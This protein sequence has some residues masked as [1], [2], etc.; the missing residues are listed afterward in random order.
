MLTDV[1][2]MY[3]YIMNLESDIS[4]VRQHAV[5]PVSAQLSTKAVV[6]LQYSE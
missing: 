6:L 2:G 3:I 1:G 4:T 5:S